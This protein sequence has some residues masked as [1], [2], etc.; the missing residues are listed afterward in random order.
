MKTCSSCNEKKPESDFQVRK[1]SKDGLTASCRQCLKKRDAKRYPKEREIRS[2][3]RKVYMSTPEGKSSHKKA[4]KQWQEK[5]ALRRAAH[6]I[7]GNALR[8][9]K[10]VKQPCFVCG[11]KAEAHHP[12]YGRPLDVVWLCTAHHKEVH[13]MVA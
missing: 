7:F 6:V 4:V 11:K 13:M 8:K 5:N 12:D 10:I 9:G 2:L 1:A 3:Q